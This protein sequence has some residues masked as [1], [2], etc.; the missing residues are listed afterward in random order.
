MVTPFGRIK[1]TTIFAVRNKTGIAL[2]I[3]MQESK[4]CH[5]NPV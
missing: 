2:R 5:F 1:K 4:P 3:K